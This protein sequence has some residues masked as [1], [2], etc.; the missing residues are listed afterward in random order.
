MINP[1]VK[2]VPLEN[3]NYVDE[4][5]AIQTNTHGIKTELYKWIDA[6][7]NLNGEGLPNSAELTKK[8]NN[9]PGY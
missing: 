7:T 2:I 4:N 9:N 6:V 5:G 8:D 1:K 3:E